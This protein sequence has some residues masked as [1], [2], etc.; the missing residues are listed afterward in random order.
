MKQKENEHL[1]PCCSKP[2]KKP[3][4]IWQGIAYGLIPHTGCII[5]I[6]ASILGATVLMQLFKPILMNEYIFYYLI[7][8]SIGFATLSSYFYLKKHDSLSLEGIKKK[9]SYLFTMYGLTIGINLILFFLAFPFLANITGNVSALEIEGLSSL[10]ITVDIPCPGHAPLISNELK[11]IN[12]VKG[13]KFNFP[14][15][16]DVYYDSSKTSQQ[17]ILSLNVFN[18]Y[19]ATEI[20]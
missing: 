4:G 16:F 19:K 9:K 2:D 20:K 17:E 1:P 14:N 8:I 6:I 12:G 7:L 18:T 15:K 5:F 11:T 3:E 10:S 13:S